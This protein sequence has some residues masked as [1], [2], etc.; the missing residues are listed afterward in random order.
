[1]A[2][3]IYSLPPCILSLF[4]PHYEV[5]ADAGRAY[6]ELLQGCKLEGVF[7]ALQLIS[8]L[9]IHEHFSRIFMG[10]FSIVLDVAR[11]TC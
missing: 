7:F 11:H 9:S 3:V 2:Y 8:M 1:M 5:T 4:P 6:A 10:V